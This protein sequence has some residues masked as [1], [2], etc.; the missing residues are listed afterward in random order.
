MNTVKGER[1]E[2]PE[3]GVKRIKRKGGYKESLTHTFRVRNL[4]TERE[5]LES[6][7]QEE[8]RLHQRKSTLT[9]RQ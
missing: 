2:E 5:V 9:N 1:A 7:R 6:R 4:V 3:K 8:G